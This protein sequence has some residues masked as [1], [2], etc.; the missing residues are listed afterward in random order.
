MNYLN[1]NRYF[2]KSDKFFVTSAAIIE[3]VISKS[4]SS[5][6]GIFLTFKLKKIRPTLTRNSRAILFS[7]GVSN[8]LYRG[9][10]YKA[11]RK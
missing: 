9:S 5:A 3:L 10:K 6:S 1:C 7:G 8:N 2:S 4:P 11:A